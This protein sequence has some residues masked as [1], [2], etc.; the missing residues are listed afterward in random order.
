MVQLL[1]RRTRAGIADGVVGD[2]IELYVMY[3][4]PSHTHTQKRA[5]AHAHIRISIE[6]RA[7]THTCSN[8]HTRERMWTLLHVGTSTHAV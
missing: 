2:R 7:H 5:S 1:A 3:V 4:Q 8:T 6:T